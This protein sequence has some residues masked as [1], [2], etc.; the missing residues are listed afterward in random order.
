[1]SETVTVQAAIDPF[2][3]VT[4]SSHRCERCGARTFRTGD[5][6]HYECIACSLWSDTI[7]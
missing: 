1:M 3:W 6:N 2:E 7:Y 5:D 4:L